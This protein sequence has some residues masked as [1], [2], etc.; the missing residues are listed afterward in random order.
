V[1]DVQ[2]LRQELDQLWARKR[3]EFSDLERMVKRVVES[4]PQ[5]FPRYDRREKGIRVAHHFNVPDV[6]PVVLEKEH[7]GRD[8]VPP[9]FA[10][11]AL[12]G[13]ESLLTYVES[14]L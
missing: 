9:K 13:V 2:A 6:Y 4:Y 11:R 1:P 5:M 14:Q 7:K 8:C 12:L 3:L 10:K